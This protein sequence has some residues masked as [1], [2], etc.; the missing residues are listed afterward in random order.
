MAAQTQWEE[1]ERQRWQAQYNE[2]AALAGGLAHEIKNPLSTIGLTLDLMAEELEGTDSPRDRRLRQRLQLIQRECRHLDEV[3]RMFLQ[4]ARLG[5]MNLV[6]CDLNDV[7]REF[8]ELYRPQAQEQGIEISPHLAAD[9]PPLPLD[10][11]LIRQMLLNLAL[12]AQDAM[13][14]GG[15][16]ELQTRLEDGQ[17]R[18]DVI[19]SGMGMDE[20]TRSRIFES[21][22]STKPAGCGLGLATVR[23]IVHAHGGDIACDSAPHRGTRFTITLPAGSD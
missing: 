20:P 10:R 6:E 16:L 17:V 1:Q 9:L 15:L 22:F 14:A 8:I 5:E 2:I 11:A 12:N 7:V 21:F 18:L 13:P 19:D 3:V 4:F 23:R